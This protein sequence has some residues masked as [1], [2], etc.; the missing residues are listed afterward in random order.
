MLVGADDDAIRIW[1][2]EDGSPIGEPLQGHD[3][4]VR[5]LAVGRMLGR[6]IV[7]S[8]STDGTVRAW[9]LADVLEIHRPSESPVKWSLAVRAGVLQ[10]R[11]VVFSGGAGGAIRTW[12][13]KSG[14]AIGPALVGY[15]SASE[16]GLHGSVYSLA[17]TVRDGRTI[18][19]SGEWGGPGPDLGCRF[20]TADR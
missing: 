11:P 6:S 9:D 20:G 10:R 13:L 16:T 2:L 14:E 15:A 19:A 12:D 17:V 4:E 3:G 7:V 1:D 8:G 18:L 5:A